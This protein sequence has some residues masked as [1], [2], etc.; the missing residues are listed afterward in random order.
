[1]KPT[2]ELRHFMLIKHY[3]WMM[4]RMEPIGNWVLQQKW[5]DENGNEEWRELPRVT[6][7]APECLYYG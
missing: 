7:E 3:E 1:M 4:G 6:E 5:V 2:L